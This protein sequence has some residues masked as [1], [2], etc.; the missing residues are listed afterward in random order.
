MVVRIA[1]D[2][3]ADGAGGVLVSV[4]DTGIGIPAEKRQMIF[5]S[6]TQADA[7]TTRRYGGTGLGLT[8]S[9]RL[10]E[11]MGGRIW[12]ES[13]EGQGSTFHFTARFGIPEEPVHA[14]ERRP[15]LRG[16]R[17]L[18]VDDNATNRLVLR[19]TLGAWAFR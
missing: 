14:A 18:V 4:S 3:G 12:L 13:T 10:V 6:F 15:D 5:Q 11:L 1:N 2:P 8:I 17:T 16:L 7:S 19:A 9:K